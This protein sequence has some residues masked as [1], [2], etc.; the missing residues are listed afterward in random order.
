[1]P[2]R[3]DAP[4]DI[5]YEDTPGV[6]LQTARGN[7]VDVGTV[8]SVSRVSVFT[9]INADPTSSRCYL[10]LPLDAARATRDAL[11]RAIVAQE[12]RERDVAI[13]AVQEALPRA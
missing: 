9:A 4:S 10:E 8:P 5:M 1:M 3:T 12:R 11:T 13:Q 6:W 7:I 2:R